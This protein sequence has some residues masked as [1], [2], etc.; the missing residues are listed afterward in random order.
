MLIVVLFEQLSND[1]EEYRTA[2]KE[3]FQV[4]MKLT[5]MREAPRLASDSNQQ[6]NQQQEDLQSVDGSVFS[7]NVAGGEPS[8]ASSS[9]TPTTTRP[10]PS[11]H[12]RLQHLSFDRDCFPSLFRKGDFVCCC[13]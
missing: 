6:Q 10:D 1:A 8:A 5:L 4:A 12:M 2:L 11:K 13:D 9:T 7:D 3:S